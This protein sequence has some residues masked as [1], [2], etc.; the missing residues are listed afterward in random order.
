MTEERQIRKTE[1]VTYQ[2]AQ[3]G[4]FENRELKRVAGAWS[5]WAL[6]VGA[7]ISGDFF[8]WNFGL[9]EGGFGGLLIATV[10]IAVMYVGLCYSIA[11]M[12]PALPHTGGAYSFGRS[13]MGP[14]GG[15]ITGLGE[16]MEYVLTPAVIVVGIG[17]YM[18]AI[19][20]DLF[21]LTIAAPLWWLLFYVAFVGLNVAGAELSFRFAIL[22]TFIAI[23]IL[24]VFYVAAIPHFSLDA[25]LNITP[26]AGGSRWLPFGITGIF[27]ALPFAIW[28]FLAIEELPLAAEE[29]HDPKRDMPKGI[30]WG[31]LTLLILAFLTLFLNS[32]V[33]P[34]AA[35]IGPSLEPLFLGFQ[36]VFGGV[37]ASV[38]ALVAV[39][40]LVASFHT[41]I[42]AYGRNIYSLSRAGYF[43]HWLSPTHGS[44]KT[45]HV[46]LV[47]G[48][49]LGYIAALILHYF[50]SGIVGA[51]L[52]TMAVFGAVISYFMQMLAFVLLRRNM[53]H[54]ERPFVSPVGVAGAVVAAII[55]AISFIS[56]F[57]IPDYRPGVLGTLVWFAAGVLYFAVVGRHRLVHSPEEEF[58]L[59]KGGRGHPELGDYGG[60]PTPGIEPAG[61][62]PA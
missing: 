54:I 62:A 13:A 60:V 16:N 10:V 45:P 6:G 3:A 28:F 39:A 21:G 37:A 41:I 42:Y 33:G 22:I 49:V 38:L 29:S 14:W 30:M 36:A 7:V 40:G 8:G 26:E 53:P 24:A 31:L 5:L 56:L 23:G 32:G 47:S 34:G 17:G 44:R 50:G 55:A 9:S 52:L 46:A 48:A 2:E 12:S 61:G 51:A 27:A 35:E 20:N 18:G 19:F 15:F 11:E 1:G 43:P 25:A 4:Y 57:L 58:A 59:T